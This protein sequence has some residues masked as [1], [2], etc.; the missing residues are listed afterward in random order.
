MPCGSTRRKRQ[1][2]SLDGGSRFQIGRP[3]PHRLVSVRTLIWPIGETCRAMRHPPPKTRCG[4]LSPWRISSGNLPSSWSPEMVAN[5]FTSR[6]VAGRGGLAC[7]LKTWRYQAAAPRVRSK[8]SV[9]RTLTTRPFRAG[10]VAVPL[11]V[12]I[13]GLTKR[14]DQT[15]VT[16]QSNVQSLDVW[17]AIRGPRTRPARL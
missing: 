10:Y 17:N 7:R 8:I 4:S 5:R 14:P 1:G 11:A 9:P 2:K 16:L 3:K 15:V 12:M 13:V 6:A